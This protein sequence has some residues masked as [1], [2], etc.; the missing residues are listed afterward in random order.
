MSVELIHKPIVQYSSF[1]GIATKIHEAAGL[2]VL[3]L[4]NNQD[5]QTALKFDPEKSRNYK[6]LKSLFQ[7]HWTAFAEH[8]SKDLG[9]DK[10][11]QTELGNIFNEGN[12]LPMFQSLIQLF[13]TASNVIKEQFTDPILNNFSRAKDIMDPKKYELLANNISVGPVNMLDSIFSAVALIP[14]IYEENFGKVIDTKTYQEIA[15]RSIEMINDSSKLHLDIFFKH[16]KPLVFGFKKNLFM[17]PVIDMLTKY[18]RFINLGS[19]EAQ[20]L[21]LAAKPELADELIAKIGDAYKDKVVFG[22]P[23]YYVDVGD[24]Q[25]IIQA[26]FKWVMDILNKYYFPNWEKIRS[27]GFGECLLTWAQRQIKE[28]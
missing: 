28:T 11:K 3:N 22:C 13:N 20:K 25:N 15:A 6:S 2:K 26:S 23:V 7:K 9:L 18:F 5:F 1:Q 8:R 21:T 16:L 17:S 19:D 10:E 14:R 4:N 12:K 27:N 24:D